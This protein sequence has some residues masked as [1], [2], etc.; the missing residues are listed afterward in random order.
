MQCV[1]AAQ[2]Q[3][4]SCLLT[5]SVHADFS[6]AQFLGGC[7]ETLNND[8]AVCRGWRAADSDLEAHFHSNSHSRTN[9][10]RPCVHHWTLGRHDSWKSHLKLVQAIYYSSANQTYVAADVVLILLSM[11]IYHTLCRSAL[12]WVLVLWLFLFIGIEKLWPLLNKH[13]LNLNSSW[14]YGK[15]GNI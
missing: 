2:L 5:C 4:C 13:P 11:Y 15:P 8:V 6:D 1:V 3:S 12:P 14:D 10:V 9:T 7:V